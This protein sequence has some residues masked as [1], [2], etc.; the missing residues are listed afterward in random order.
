MFKNPGKKLKTLSVIFFC[1]MSLISIVMAFEYGYEKVYHQ[2][3]FS[4]Y[5]TTRFNPVPFFSLLIGGPFVSYVFALIIRGLGQMIENDQIGLSSKT[6][7][8]TSKKYVCR[9]CGEV[10]DTIFM[11]CPICGEKY[12]EKN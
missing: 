5:A 2:D 7:E 1:V 12:E 9:K 6:R 4:S 11:Y 8:D 10:R 3:F